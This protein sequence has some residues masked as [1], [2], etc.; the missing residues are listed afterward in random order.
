[1]LWFLALTE[2]HCFLGN[3]TLNDEQQR[4]SQLSVILVQSSG[5]LIGFVGVSAFFYFGKLGELSVDTYK[6][7]LNSRI[8]LH[9]VKNR[10]VD[11]SE[12]LALTGAKAPPNNK[13]LKAAMSK[14]MEI[15]DR[16]T[17]KIGEVQKKQEKI[18]EASKN[19]MSTSTKTTL[20]F[21]IAQVVSLASALV[22]C[23]GSIIT[24]QRIFLEAS[25]YSF[26]V[27]IGFIVL[28][29]YVMGEMSNDLANLFNEFM[30]LN[31]ELMDG[32]DQSKGIHR[33]VCRLRTEVEVVSKG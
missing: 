13:T 9:K 1:M 2:I 20:M 31:V 17:S 26:G 25:I 18:V 32:Y 29:I 22:L 33:S 23:L 7:A 6:E 15:T 16:L 19:R 14:F 10:L 3:L 24:N 11:I 21:L 4:I 27:G 8:L 28:G 12:E 30:M 5:I